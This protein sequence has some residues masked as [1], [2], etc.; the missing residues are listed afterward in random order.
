MPPQ[1]SQRYT[2][3]VPSLLAVTI[4]CPL[5]PANAAPI[6]RSVGPWSKNM[7]RPVDAETT[8]AVLGPAV[9]PTVRPG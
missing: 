4:V 8:P 2:R 6:S 5:R 1:I 7:R 3:I 9:Q